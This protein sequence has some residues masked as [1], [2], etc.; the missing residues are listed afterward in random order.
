MPDA[1]VDV[2]TIRQRFNFDWCMDPESGPD[3]V[4]TYWWW[5][6]S[7]RVDPNELICDD[8]EGNL[9]SVPFSTDGADAVT[10]GE[11]TR[12]RE[13]FVPVAAADGQA[14]TAVVQ[15]RR[16]KTVAAAMERP[17]KEARPGESNPS[18][19]VARP[20]DEEETSTMDVDATVLRTRLGLPEDATEDSIIEALQ[21][22]PPDTVTPEQV[23]Q[24]VAA[25]R[26]EERQRAAATTDDETVRFDRQTAE[27][28]QADAQAGREAR[29]QQIAAQR[30]Q[31]V[32]NAVQDGRIAPARREH[33]RAALNADPEGAA[34]TLE[35][36]SKGLIPVD[37]RGSAKSDDDPSATAGQGTGLFPH[38]DAQKEA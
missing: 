6:R 8:D 34:Q 32:A 28:L 18:A 37:E 30:D 33:W 23:E 20:T 21:A 17:T 15:R 22:M 13:T 14:A 26:E 38:L 2:G 10:F 7:I 11:P 36:L 31:V 16:Q 19:A 9:W 25:A 27:Q 4:D 35:G 12:V 1:S 5:A 24:Q 29:E 3:G